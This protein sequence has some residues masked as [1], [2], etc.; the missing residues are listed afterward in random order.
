M[1]QTSGLK[2]YSLKKIDSRDAH[3]NMIIGERSNGKTFS[4][5]EKIIRN[6]RETGEQGAYIRRWDDDFKRGRGQQVFEGLKQAGKITQITDGEYDRVVF[7]SMAWYLAKYDDELKKDITDPTPVCYAFSLTAMEHNKSTNYD[8]VTIIAFDEFLSHTSYLPNEFTLFTNTLSTIIR[9]RSNVKIYMLANTV[10]KYSPYFAEMGITN[11]KNQKQGTID[12]YEY[13]ESGLKV[14]VEYCS[15][16]N[17]AGKPSDV[18][19]AF[20]NPKLQMITN[21]IWELEIYPHCPCKYK[22]KDVMFSY[23]INFD[24]EL[25]QCDIVNTYNEETHSDYTFTFIHRKTTPLRNPDTDLIYTTEQIVKPNYAVRIDKPYLKVHM[26]VWWF[27]QHNSVY[28]QDN[29]VGE[30]VRNY[31]TW[32]KRGS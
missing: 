24:G 1:F 23:F 18:Y 17:K 6:Y 32:C 27:F 3:Y 30:I 5:L 28:Y 10:N 13:G 9:H 12:V 16:L 2:F 7:K 26:K 14:A 20:G 15:T 21:G 29:E 22:P 11:I 31:L 25:L 19:F 4:V 8:G